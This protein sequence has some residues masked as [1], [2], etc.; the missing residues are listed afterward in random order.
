MNNLN[1]SQ[2]KVLNLPIN[3]A[4]PENY[5]GIL[6]WYN[7]DKT[8]YCIAYLKDGYYHR[9]DGPAVEYLNKYKAWYKE[10]NLH[11]EDGPAVVP[12]NDVPSWWLEDILFFSEESTSLDFRNAVVLSKEPHPK[13]PTVKIWKIL[14]SENISEFIII[15]G[16]EIYIIE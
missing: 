4:P 3:E 7:F 16:M 9:E 10:G 2:I 14:D 6:N 11:R 8:L 12:K 1:S 15:P 5:T 13:Y